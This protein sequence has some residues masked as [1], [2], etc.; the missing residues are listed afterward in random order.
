M[1]V[2]TILR[3]YT[4]LPSVMYML[5]EKKLT[6]LD[7]ASWDD[8]NDSYYLRLYKDRRALKSVLAL[9][10]TQASETYHHWR[11][12]APASSGVCVCFHRDALLSAVEPTPGLRSGPVRYR[13]LPTMRRRK[14]N[15]RD[16]PFLKRL[17]FKQ[18]EEFRLVY[19]SEDE[20]AATKDV[21]IPITAVDRVV[22][23]PWMP[24]TLY[25][26]VKTSLRGLPGCSHLSVTRSTLIGNDEWKK[27]GD[28]ASYP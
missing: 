23:S 13:A 25:G 9:C 10:F 16:L 14:P 3:R 22:I 24:K 17:A 26:T 27:A 15:V 18:E 19:D 2:D 5:S 4:N 1:V 20:P 21:P 7:P 11:V 8:T 6:L 12:F 28:G